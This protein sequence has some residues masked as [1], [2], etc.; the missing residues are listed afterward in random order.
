MST[1]RSNMTW[2]K[3]SAGGRN[4]VYVGVGRYSYW[5]DKYGVENNA[6]FDTHESTTSLLVKVHF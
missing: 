1:R 3:P 6:N 2:A 4:E 5:K